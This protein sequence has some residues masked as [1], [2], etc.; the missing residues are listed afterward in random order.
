MTSPDPDLGP[1]G[2]A[3]TLWT[4]AILVGAAI[5]FYAWLLFR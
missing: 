1:C 5:G 3:V 2:C 4:V